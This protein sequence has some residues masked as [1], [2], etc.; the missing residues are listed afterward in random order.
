MQFLAMS[1]LRWRHF[2]FE[3]FENI[4]TT[5]NALNGPLAFDKELSYWPSIMV[6]ALARVRILQTFVPK[7]WEAKRANLLKA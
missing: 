4:G 1:N 6:N 5:D 7:A 2:S 3:S